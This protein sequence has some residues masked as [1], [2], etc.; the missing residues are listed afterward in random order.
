MLKFLYMHLSHP[1]WTTAISGSLTLTKRDKE[2]W[3]GFNILVFIDI[4]AIFL[5]LK[6][7]QKVVK[8]VI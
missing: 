3:Y 1:G 2:I 8:F 4:F 5:S 6:P 7:N